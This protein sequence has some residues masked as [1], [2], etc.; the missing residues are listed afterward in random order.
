MKL[1]SVQL[2]EVFKKVDKEE[3]IGFIVKA[4]VP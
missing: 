4:I 1:D 2:T 3:E